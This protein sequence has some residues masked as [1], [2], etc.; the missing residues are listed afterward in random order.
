MIFAQRCLLIGTVSQVS[1]VAHGPLVFEQD[2]NFFY[3]NFDDNFFYSNFDLVYNCKILNRNILYFQHEYE[4]EL[5]C[6]KVKMFN[7]D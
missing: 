1:D 3:S 6:N 7:L 5:V 2:D 4:I